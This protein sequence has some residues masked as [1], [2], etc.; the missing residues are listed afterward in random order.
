MVLFFYQK[1]PGHEQN[2]QRTL[3]LILHPQPLKVL[4][5][6]SLCDFCASHTCSVLTGQLI[7][8]D[9]RD[10]PSFFML[11]SSMFNEFNRW[12]NQPSAMCFNAMH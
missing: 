10:S 3:A 11:S 12:L 5:V 2:S 4:P 1:P 7:Q 8:I 6:L 9:A